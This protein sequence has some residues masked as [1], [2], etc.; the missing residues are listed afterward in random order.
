MKKGQKQPLSNKGQAGKAALA[1]VEEITS[2]G[3]KVIGV[4]VAI[5]VLGFI[6]LSRTDSLGRNWAS[7]LSPF[8]ILGGYLVIAIGIFLPENLRTSPPDQSH[9]PQ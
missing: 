1:P 3:K 6:V 9:L 8:L 5:L 4:G 7:T 2:L